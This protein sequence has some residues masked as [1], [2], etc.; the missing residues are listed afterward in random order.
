MRMGPPTQHTHA[1]HAATAAPWDHGRNTQPCRRKKIACWQPLAQVACPMPSATSSSATGA[2]AARAH[3]VVV[4]VKDAAE[5]KPFKRSVVARFLPAFIVCMVWIYLVTYEHGPL[6]AFEFAAAHNASFAAA[7][8]GTLWN[9]L[10]ED[11]YPMT[12]AMIFG[13]LIAGSTPLGGGVVA[14]PVAV[15]LI[16]FEP[17]EGRDYTV[18][19][20]TVGMNAAAYL[21]VLNKSHLLDFNLIATF[22]VVG[23]PGV[24]CGLALKLAPFYVVL[25]FQTLVLE[26]AFI[27]FYLN[28]LA[29]RSSPSA[30]PSPPDIEM[31]PAAI[32]AAS[33]INATCGVDGDHADDDQAAASENPAALRGDGSHSPTTVI[34]QADA[35]P[36]DDLVPASRLRWLGINATMWLAAF[37]GGFLTANVGSGSDIMLY[38][39]GLLGWNMLV[40][41]KHRLSDTSLTAS[42]VVVMGLLS[43]VT[44]VWCVAALAPAPLAS[45]ASLPATSASALRPSPAP[46][47]RVLRPS[48]L[49]RACV[50]PR[51]HA[52]HLDQR[53]LLLGRHLLARVLRRAAR[54]AAAHAGAAR[55]A[56]HRLLS[57]RDRPVRRLRRDQGQGQAHR[58]DHLRVGDRR[59]LRRP[60]AALEVRPAQARPAGRRRREARRERL[61]EAPAQVQYSNRTVMVAHIR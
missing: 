59:R 18:I 33:S 19:I 37:A 4:D 44:T 25:L 57:S 32:A 16:G 42:S 41:E 60:R 27:F 2:S 17:S 3:D 39:Y 38:A 10:F 15:L 47:A 43:L 1:W 35:G 8:L 61:Q 21:I 54:L 7:P 36:C 29:P 26:F 56:A 6:N 50:Q 13:S 51:L 30:V 28:I 5:E 46:S 58:V 9:E 24:L 22:T 55:A 49:A 20:Q 23:V 52:R 34:N 31:R 45:A 11:Y 53:P 12:L 48:S 14:F 40:P